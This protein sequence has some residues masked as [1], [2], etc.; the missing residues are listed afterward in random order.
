M[1]APM[2]TADLVTTN[3]LGLAVG[4]LASFLTWWVLFHWFVPKVEFSAFISKIP[5]AGGSGYSYRIKLMNTGRRSILG[6]EV[7]A[8]L[9]VDWKG[10]GNWLGIYLPFSGEGEKK[11]DIPILKRGGDRV[12][13]FFINAVH[14]FQTNVAYPEDFRRKAALRVVSMEDVLGLGE[15]AYV[16]VFVSG[17]DGFSGARRVFESRKFHTSDIYPNRFTK[18]GLGLGAPSNAAS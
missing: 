11:Y 15:N 12:L 17:Y 9:W 2:T 13:S 5:R 14:S 18:Q 7:H 16:Q 3:L 6:V 8:R 10:S 4:V 1:D